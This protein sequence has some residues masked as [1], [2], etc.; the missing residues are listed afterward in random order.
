MPTRMSELPS[1]AVAPAASVRVEAVVLAG[2]RGTRLGA[3]VT[4]VPKPMLAVLGRPFLEWVVRW[5]AGQAIRRVFLST[6]Y[7]AGVVEAHFRTCPVP[8]VEVT[9]VAEPTA[10]GTAGGVLHATSQARERPAAWLVLNGDSLTLCSLKPLLA[11]LAD[12]A[13][14]GAL[15][16]V[17]VDEAARYGTL[18]VGADGALAGFEEKRPGAG[19]IS[20][21]VYL[22]RPRL[23]EGLPERRPLSFEH[24]VFPFLVRQGARLQVLVVEAPFLDIGTPET[25]AQAEAFLRRHGGAFL[26]L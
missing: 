24:D 16:G 26:A 20:A 17:R 7:L 19:V 18:R 25:L 8:E 11:S 23:L 1:A 15:L 13:V 21:G 12:P 10:L 9:C 5:L 3:S 2:G 22:L 6:G 4:T 14:D